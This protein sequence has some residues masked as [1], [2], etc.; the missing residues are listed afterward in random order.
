MSVSD[1]GSPFSYGAEAAA[2][3][4]TLDAAIGTI[5]AGKRGALL[6]RYVLNPDGTQSESVQVAAKLGSNWEV[7]AGG[8]WDGNVTH[9][10]GVSFAV[11]G[12]W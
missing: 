11:A 12:S 4:A 8:A 2:V 10:P 3:H 1:P 7:A 5:P 9:K 6:T